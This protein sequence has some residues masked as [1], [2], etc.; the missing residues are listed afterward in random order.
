MPAATLYPLRFEPIL[1]E[2][3]WGGDALREIFGRPVGPEQR[4]GESWELADRP[5]D[6]SRIVNGPLRGRLLRD[7]LAEHPRDLL[8]AAASPG[9]LAF[10]LMVKYID[11]RERLSLQVHPPAPVAA[12]LGAEPKS[13]MW[14]VVRAAPGSCI[15]AGL[16]AGTAPEELEA[17]LA[18]GRIEDCVARHPARAGDVFFLP[19]GT[20]HAL[21]SGNVVIEIQ[22][23][24]DTTYRVHDWG[25]LEG[26]S[27]VRELHVREAMESIRHGETHPRIDPVP[28]D[29]DPEGGR[30]ERLVHSPCFIVVRRR[31]ENGSFFIRPRPGSCRVWVVIGGGGELETP[32]AIEALAPGDLL[33]IPASAPPLRLT[34][35][36]GGLTLLEARVPNTEADGPALHPCP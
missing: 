36:G 19:S 21:G 13:E 1:K 28:S 29:Q 30:I 34:S 18:A 7:I 27:R 16:R 14:Y 9:A 24:S 8:G 6:S 22:Q 12:A 31:F 23:N 17:T 3:I 26:G 32:A 11:A 33:L 20:L 35:R 15:Y 10:P 5:G 2:R 4:I 25:R